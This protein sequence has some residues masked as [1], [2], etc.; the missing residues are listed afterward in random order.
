MN[1]AL[2]NSVPHLHLT[3]VQDK[4]ITSDYIIIEIVKEI[5]VSIFIA[6]FT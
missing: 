1:A 3:N 2:L 4:A 5:H 6:D